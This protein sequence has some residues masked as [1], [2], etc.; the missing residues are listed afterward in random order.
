V[1]DGKATPEQTP[2]KGPRSIYRTRAKLWRYAGAKASWYFFTL[3]Q[4]VAREIRLVDAGPRRQGFGSLRVEATV[5]AT[6][7]S[8]S[9]FPSASHE[10]Y[11]LPVKASVRKAEKLAE[12]RTVSLQVEVARAW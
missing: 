1:N 9:I 4:R 8:T 7:W 5:G 12:G 6:S 3:P 11:L 2:A 10:T